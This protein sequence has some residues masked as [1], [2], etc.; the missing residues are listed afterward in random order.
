MDMNIR[1][2]YLFVFLTDSFTSHHLQVSGAESGRVSLFKKIIASRYL[3]EKFDVSV[4]K[5]SN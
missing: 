3:M 1:T 2:F 4:F 5:S